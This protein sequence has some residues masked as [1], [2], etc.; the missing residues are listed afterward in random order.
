MKLGII[1]FYEINDLLEKVNFV[2]FFFYRFQVNELRACLNFRWPTKS[3]ID[4][5]E[6]KAIKD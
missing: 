4:C 6:F 5:S 1:L 2:I 3:L